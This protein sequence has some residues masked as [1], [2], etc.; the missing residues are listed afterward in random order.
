MLTSAAARRVAG[1]EKVSTLAEKLPGFDLVGWSVVV[2]PKGTP[3]AAIRRE[4]R[5]LNALLNDC[6][7]A[8]RI[9]AISPLVAGTMI[10]AQ[11]AQ[12]LRDPS[13][14]CSAAAKGIGVLP[15]WGPSRVLPCPA[16]SRSTGRPARRVALVPTSTAYGLASAAVPTQGVQPSPQAMFGSLQGPKLPRPQGPPSVPGGGG[17]G[18]AIGPPGLGL[19]GWSPPEPDGPDGASGPAP[20]MCGSSASKITFMAMAPK[21][22]GFAVTSCMHEP[23]APACA[24]LR[25]P[26]C[27]KTPTMACSEE[28][29]D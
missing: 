4:N 10:V 5:D 9:G 17:G 12:F 26:W 18:S 1:W 20:G 8:E 7:E 3:S 28:A 11:V 2:A 14:R 22:G 25:H 19:V 27:P 15:E 29:Q 16:G 13:A 6:E 21:G 23:G 24:T